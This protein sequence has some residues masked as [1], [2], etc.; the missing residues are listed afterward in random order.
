[1]ATNQCYENFL[2]F[3]LLAPSGV[4]I[5]SNDLLIFGTGS[6]SMVGVAQTSQ[7]VGLAAPYNDNT[8]YITLQTSGAVNISVRGFVSSSPSAGAQIRRGDPVY[9]DGGTKDVTSGITYGN[10]VDADANGTFVGIAMDPVAA[11]ATTT[12]RVILKNSLGS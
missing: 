4:A 5:N 6:K 12:I 2:R 10:T 8:G 7:A 11:G 9:A 3:E 1:M